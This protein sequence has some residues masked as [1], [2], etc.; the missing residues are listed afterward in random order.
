[1]LL[2]YGFYHICQEKMMTMI[3]IISIV[4]R[5]ICPTFLHDDQSRILF[6]LIGLLLLSSLFWKILRYLNDT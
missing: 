5:P 2:V 3:Q 4:S 1:M 6:I